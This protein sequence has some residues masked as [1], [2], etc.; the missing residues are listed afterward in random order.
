MTETGRVLSIIA[1]TSLSPEFALK[2]R[3]HASQL[4][5]LFIHYSYFSLGPLGW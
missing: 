2:A 5:L 4:T 1:F 3:A